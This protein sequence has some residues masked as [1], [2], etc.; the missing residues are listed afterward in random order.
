MAEPEDVLI[1]AA[2]HATIAIG[3]LWE[4]QHSGK[5]AEQAA[6]LN[7]Q[8]G[9]LALLITAVFD[10]EPIIKVAQPPAPPSFLRRLFQALP[11]RLN[12]VEA[13]PSTDGSSIYLPRRLNDKAGLPATRWYRVLALQQAG[14]LL[15][16]SASFVPTPPAS[17]SATL[18]QL[19]EAAAVDRFIADQLP[20][21]IADLQ[22]LRAAM[23]AARPEKSLLTAPEW[24]V[25]AHYRSLLQDTPLAAAT[26]PYAADPA[27]SLHWAQ[28]EAEHIQRTAE[29]RFRGFRLDAWLGQLLPPGDRDK[30]I[31]EAVDAPE[32]APQRPKTAELPRRPEVREADADED[33]ESVGMWMLQMDDPHEQVEDPMGMQRPA[34]RDAGSNPDETA[35]ALSE[36]PQARLAATPEPAKEVF[37]SDDPPE[38]QTALQQTEQ[39][40]GIRY[41][42]WDYRI[43]AYHEAGATVWLKSCTLGA[44][45]WAEQVMQRR[46]QLLMEVRRRF[47]GLR[48]RRMQVRRQLDGEDV[49]ITAYVEAYASRQ[50]GGAIDERF[51]QSVRPARRDVAISLLVDISGSTDAWIGDDLRIID[52]EKEALLICCQAL[53]ALGD[54]YAIHAYSGEGPHG[55]AVWPVK[56]FEQQDQQL[57]Q[58][59]IAALEPEH[60]T[61][62]GAA[63]RHATAQL[64]QRQEQH[65]LLLLLSDG[66]PNDCDEYEGR[67]G[68]EDM[69]QAVVEATAASIHSFCLTVDRN[70]PNYLTAIF[71]TG[72][73][74]VLPHPRHLP[75]AL[76]D[77][78][79]QLLRS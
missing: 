63:M 78:L 22:A 55:V 73:H 72:Q 11:Q 37:V 41:P 17:L 28:Q 23:L 24:E 64:A 6:W 56:E 53:N 71:G 68:V 13:L 10:A 40:L 30:A 29:G 27:A 45:E 76:I 59:R 57:V 74:A 47:E 34:D 31:M 20:G 75:V 58:Q 69:R 77:V 43:A 14:R 70:A 60:Y 49:D 52:V 50:A 38:S 79:R 35:D 26:L 67:Y 4:R 46:R 54:P 44:P 5:E 18:Y 42:E 36:L 8:R 19:S 65:R 61:R 51:Y 16:G 1:D 7:E 33:D 48:P 9:R 3:R 39:R 32:S 12:H 21:L 15:R 25:E 2:R 62:S 66:K